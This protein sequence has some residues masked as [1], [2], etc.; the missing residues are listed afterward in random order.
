M[1]NIA[2]SHGRSVQNSSFGLSAPHHL[3]LATACTL[4]WL[5][6]LLGLL[7]SVHTHAELVD[8]WTF[9]TTEGSGVTFTSSGPRQTVG[10]QYRCEWVQTPGGQGLRFDGATSRAVVRDSDNYGTE[11]KA[12]TVECWI[13][14]DK[15]AMEGYRVLITKYHRAN[16]LYVTLRD[17]RFGHY[18]TPRDTE[19]LTPDQW[20]H[21]VYVAEGIGK[22]EE[23]IYVDGKER[24]RQPSEW[25]GIGKSD[26]NIEIG[27]VDGKSEIFCGVI[28]EI[29]LYDHGLAAD[30][31]AAHFKAGPKQ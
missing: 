6:A 16:E 11:F 24:A 2:F 19:P 9:N 15:Q 13:K 17:G 3:R 5:P 27:V 8:A 21:V 23:I 7:C 12:L 18:P 10:E 29:R 26:S 25:K 4:N 1:K 30:E 14:P 28:D 31:V 22:G 20:H